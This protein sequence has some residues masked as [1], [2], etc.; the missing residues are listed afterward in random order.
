MF[1]EFFLL[2]KRL[3]IAVYCIEK[4]SRCKHILKISR[5]AWKMLQVTPIPIIDQFYV[6]ESM[7]L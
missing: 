3:A 4:K 5:I 7:F 6:A 2:Y 1:D